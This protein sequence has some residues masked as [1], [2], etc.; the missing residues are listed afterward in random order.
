MNSE[1]ANQ[2]Q[3]HPV[4]RNI[5]VIVKRLSIGLTYCPVAPV[6]TISFAMLERTKGAMTRV[7]RKMVSYCRSKI[8]IIADRH[9]IV[10][11]MSSKTLII[12]CEQK[13]LISEISPRIHSPRCQNIPIWK[14]EVLNNTIACYTRVI[15]DG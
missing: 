13:S 4:C 11:Y 6:T 5:Q 9:L 14:V 1:E 10:E 3:S 7:G 12:P 2:R 15:H 8:D